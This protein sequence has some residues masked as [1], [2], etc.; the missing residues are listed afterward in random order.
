MIYGFE[1]RKNIKQK[2]IYETIAKEILNAWDAKSLQDIKRK[3][4]QLAKKYHPDI[5]KKNCAQKKFQDITLSYRILTNWDDSI[6]NEKFSTIDEFDL[7][8]INIK[9]KIKDEKSIFDQYKNIY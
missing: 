8:I 5:N 7:K 3:Y 6:L 4:L 1:F 2:R 9:A